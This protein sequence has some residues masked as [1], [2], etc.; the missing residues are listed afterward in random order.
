MIEDSP[1]DLDRRDMAKLAAGQ[2][3]ALNE[4]MR[5]HAERLF[6][7]LIRL[8][9]NE[10]EA[11]DLA[12]EA[13]VRVYEHRQKYRSGSKFST[14]LYSIATNLA[15]DQLRRRS[16]HPQVS[17][18]STHPETGL[19]FRESLPEPGLNP[20]ESLQA[21]ERAKA[22]QLAVAGLPEELQVPLVL[23]E[24]ENQSQAEIAAMLRCSPK[25]VEMRLYRAR[26]LL[27]GKLEQV[28]GAL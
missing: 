19:D 16:R 7:Y 18:E 2:D 22:V 4:L 1:D 26:Q 24:Y 20:G 27:R 12:E 15:R 8:L 17:L 14:W 11:A 13:F 9:Q 6:R 5:R 28:W 21:A 10:S 3:S 25:A 23:A